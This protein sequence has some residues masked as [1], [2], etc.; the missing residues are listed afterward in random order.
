LFDGL[1]AGAGYLTEMKASVNSNAQ[2]V[3]VRGGAGIVVAIPMYLIF[4]ELL[5]SFG[6]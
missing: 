4:P 6:E 1:D 3:N 2:K 5:L